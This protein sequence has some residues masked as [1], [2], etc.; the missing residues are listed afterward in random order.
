MLGAN[1]ADAEGVGVA[2]RLDRGEQRHIIEL[3]GTLP[4]SL[5]TLRSWD[6]WSKALWWA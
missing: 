5:D 1:V 2:A 3:G 4:P 6:V